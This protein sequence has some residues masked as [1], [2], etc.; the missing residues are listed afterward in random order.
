MTIEI[1]K[2]FDVN[3]KVQ[4]LQGS[5]N[6]LMDSTFTKLLY[7]RVHGMHG[8]KEINNDKYFFLENLCCLHSMIVEDVVLVFLLK[9]I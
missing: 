4:S 6:N 3:Q 8:L 5:E 1:G 9:M 2:P 7:L